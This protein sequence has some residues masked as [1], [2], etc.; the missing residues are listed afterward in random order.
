MTLMGKWNSQ[1]VWAGSPPLPLKGSLTRG[2][3]N[4]V[5]PKPSE[6]KAFRNRRLQAACSGIFQ[7][8][9]VLWKKRVCSC[10]D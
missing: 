4:K 2:L 9:L 7:E 10:E 3:Q 1:R 5:K 8:K 6:E